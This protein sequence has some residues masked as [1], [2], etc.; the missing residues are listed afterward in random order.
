MAFRPSPIRAFLR[1]ARNLLPKEAHPVGRYPSAGPTH[2]VSWG[3]Y[4]TKVMRTAAWYVPVAA[5]ILGWPVPTGMV[6]NK[7][8]ERRELV[9]HDL[10]IFT[11]PPCTRI[12]ELPPERLVKFA[13]SKFKS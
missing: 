11:K 7:T 3:I 9:A 1:S 4:R 6:L 12:Y 10:H 13:A 8:R 5:V 2:P